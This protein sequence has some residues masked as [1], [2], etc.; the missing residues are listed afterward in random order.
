MKEWRVQW[1]DAV[2]IELE[3]KYPGHGRRIHDVLKGWANLPRT[4]IKEQLEN[5][6]FEILDD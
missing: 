6:A 4:K 2:E 5:L 1:L 3:A